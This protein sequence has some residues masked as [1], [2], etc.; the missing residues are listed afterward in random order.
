MGVPPA[1]VRPIPITEVAPS[2]PVGGPVDDLAEQVH[3]LH[4]RYRG[5]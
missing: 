4:R 3:E 1:P 5:R 2:V